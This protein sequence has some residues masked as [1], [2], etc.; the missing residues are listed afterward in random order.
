MS[1]AQPAYLFLLLLLPLLALVQRKWQQRFAKRLAAFS[2]HA[3]ITSTRTH[4]QSGLLL[5]GLACL[6]L[7]LAGPGWGTSSEEVVLRSRN[8]MLAI[9]VSRSMLAEDVRPNRLDRAKADLIDL[10]DA[11]KGDRA[12]L[13]AFRGKGALFCPMT[14]DVAFLRQSIESLAPDM[15]PPGETDLADAIR[16]CLD[17]FELAQSSHNAIILVSDGEDLAGRAEE[18]A[19]IAGEKHIPI[20][21]VGIGS[22]RGAEIPEGTS[23]LKYEGKVVTSHLTESTLQAIADASG[24]RYIPLATAGTA[25]TTLGAVYARYLTHLA[26]EE[27]RER[28][29]HHF[30]DKTW[31][32]ATLAALCCLVAGL[33]SLGRISLARAMLFAVLLT[34]VASAQEPARAAQRLYRKGDYAQAAEQ[35]ALARM[36][37]DPAQVAHYAYNEALALWKQGDVTNALARVQL[38]LEEDDFTARAATLEGTL[39]LVLAEA[40]TDA[41]D[42]LKAREAAITAFTRALRAEPSTVAERNLTRALAEIESVRYEARKVAALKQYKE[43]PLQQMIPQ[44]LQHQRA[45]M[46]AVPEVFNSTDVS[47]RLGQA[48]QLATDVRTQADRWFPVLETLPQV[49]TN[50]TMCLEL[51]QRAR[52]AQI[53]LD[54]VANAYEA[55][56]AEVAPLNEGEP[57]VYDF[58]KLVAQPDHLIEEAIAVQTN[59]LTSLYRYQPAR[60]DEAE[61]LNL[62]QQ[63]RVMFPQWSEELMKA[64]GESDAEPT[65]TPE[66]RDEI[67]RLADAT[68]PLLAPPVGDENK[69]KVMENLLRIRELL[70]KMK[71][72]SQSQNGE[73]QQKQDSQQ[74]E[75]PQDQQEQAQSDPQEQ[76]DQRPEDTE[77][78]A[79]Q[80][81][82]EDIESLLQK[83][84]DREREHEEE[85]RKRMMQHVRPNARDW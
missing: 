1:F 53:A 5:G 25:Q 83:A 74:S 28:A 18:L 56:E 82:D 49:V 23:S 35:Y 63:F 52:A 8:V 13:L 62:V 32:F 57:F 78:Q 66:M 46:K 17:T 33:L 81:Q 9:D 37:A 43:T 54:E 10:V 26:D 64:Q 15:A 67:A 39:Q 38:A 40:A 68:V 70:P 11:L 4:V 65:F 3:Q 84:I 22:T 44:L 75:S 69:R 21:T 58:W 30:A 14:T 41:E 73:E 85:K 36:S 47:V 50:E 45:L 55:M 27:A 72:P 12:G 6:I 60:D 59:A 48:E 80:A 20:F 19:K 31:L 79:E 2:R 51:S 16:K 24:G 76:Q 61:V 34:S 7:A 71:N 29:E 77:Q 42:R